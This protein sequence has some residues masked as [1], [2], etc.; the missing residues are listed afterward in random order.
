ML[1]DKAYD[2]YDVFASSLV[3]KPPPKDATKAEKFEVQ[4]SGSL[5]AL[6]G[7][8]H[9]LIGGDNVPGSGATGN[10][11]GGH[12]S[13]VP[14][15][16]FDPIFWMHHCQIDHLFALWQSIH[17]DKP[18]N[19]FSSPDVAKAKLLPF[20]TEAGDGTFWNSNQSAV[21]DDFGYTY[22]E[23]KSTGQETWAAVGHMYRWSVPLRKSHD[24]NPAPPEIEPI[25][26]DDSYFFQFHVETEQAVAPLLS[27]TKGV[28][29]QHSLFKR[30]AL[31]KEI[32]SGPQATA[33]YSREWFVDDTI[34]R[35]L[36]ILIHVTRKG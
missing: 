9:G 1:S 22:P 24:T 30:T 15:A 20:R 23:I 2:E 26:V 5:E 16:A 14:T 6:H 21:T 25:S 13:R 34:Q 36:T 35:Y 3:S 4:A 11:V 32:E 29:Q 33:G 19:W 27:E 18:N 28:A 10:A 17:K 12:M 8:Y 31:L 7:M